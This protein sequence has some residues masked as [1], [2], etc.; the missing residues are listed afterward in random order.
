VGEEETV[1]VRMDVKES[2][3]R[4]VEKTEE[5]EGGCVG[6]GGG[7]RVRWWKGGEGG[8]RR[9]GRKKGLGIVN[10]KDG[11]IGGGRELS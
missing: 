7:R 4:G 8:I 5:T 11:G 1:Y 9:R 2:E 6:R 3:G 10:D